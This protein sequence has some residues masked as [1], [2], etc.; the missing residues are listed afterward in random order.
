M[1]KPKPPKL[2]ELLTR[3]LVMQDSGR[4]VDT[5]TLVKELKV[6]VFGAS[7]LM[8]MLAKGEYMP[9]LERVFEHPEAPLLINKDVTRVDFIEFLED[10]PPFKRFQLVDEELSKRDKDL[11][12]SLGIARRR[13]PEEFRLDMV[14]MYV[15]ADQLRDQYRSDFRGALTTG[16]HEFFRRQFQGKSDAEIRDGLAK[17]KF[18]PSEIEAAFRILRSE[19]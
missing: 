9:A 17:L 12:V 10:M 2:L 13:T 8:F 3:A 18:T 7:C 16:D 15:L 19:V 11:Y 5:G 14:Q 1:P 4:T 6:T